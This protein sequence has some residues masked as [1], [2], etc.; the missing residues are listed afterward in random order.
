[1][2]LGVENAAGKVGM[3]E[4]VEVATQNLLSTLCVCE[5]EREL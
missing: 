5:R 1:M 2:C 3:G 4:V